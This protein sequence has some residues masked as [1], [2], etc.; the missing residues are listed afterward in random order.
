M[1]ALR[2]I[3]MLQFM[4]QITDK[5]GWDH[6]IFDNIIT[7]KWKD[8]V[9][10]SPNVNFTNKMA[11]YCIN[12]LKYK[13]ELFK[14]TGF[15]HI[16][17]RDVIKSDTAIPVDLQAALKTAITPLEN[18]PKCKQD[19]HPGSNDMVLD[20]VHPSLFL[21]MYG[22][23]HILRDDTV[24]LENYINHSG[25]DEM[26]PEPPEEETTINTLSQAQGGYSRRFQWLPCAVDI[27]GDTPKIVSYINNLHPQDHAAL[28]G[29]V[30]QIIAHVIPLWNAT[31]APLRA[32]NDVKTRIQ[33]ADI[34]Y[35][36]LEDLVEKEG[37]TREDGEDKWTFLDRQE[38]WK[39]T[40]KK[41]FIVLP[42]PEPFEGGSD[43]SEED[44]VDLKTDF[45]T[46]ELQ[47][48]VK[49]ANIHL[50]PEKPEYQG[51][52]WHVEGHLNEHICATTIYY[53][54]NKNITASHLAFCQP[55]SVVL[56]EDVGYEQGDWAWLE[57]VYGLENNEP[58][59]QVV[60]SV[61]AREGRLVTFPNILQHRVQPFRLVD[62]TKPGHRKILALFLVDPN[63]RIIST[64]NIPCQQRDWWGR[65]VAGA[66]KNLPV[67]LR[68]RVV[69][70]VG[71]FPISL[72]RAKEL[73]EELMAERKEYLLSYQETNF[74]SVE[75]SLCEH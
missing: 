63:I 17:N 33:Y 23:L 49:F 13:A 73:R 20:L 1:L 28:Y 19:W 37:P 52:T 3:T 36:D 34:D 51:G 61:E 10:Q 38:D 7:Q 18:V 57:S 71:D 2:E 69:W 24:D 59:V 5:P 48:I 22:L 21:L 32:L 66:L 11:D 72:E 16:Y 60:G 53:Y 35:G 15:I 44:R 47:I 58:A 42:N 70:D 75:I 56:I 4:N 45:D 65:E 40:K 50:T 9:L 62:P 6:K 46:T 39:N 68:D 8:E 14:Q 27:S 26:V 43:S 41:Q 67:E 29:I 30:E 64:A 54:D 25:Q 55:S 31:L 12:K 74:S